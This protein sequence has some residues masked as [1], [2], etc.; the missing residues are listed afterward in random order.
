LKRAWFAEPVPLWLTILLTAAGTYL[1]TVIVRWFLPR[2][3]KIQHEIEHLYGVHDEQFRR[4]MGNLL[5]PAILGG[6][7]VTALIN[8]REIFPAMLAAIGSARRSITF[9]TFIYWSGEIGRRFADALADRARAGVK[10]HVLLD[11]LGSKRMDE[12]YLRLMQDAGVQVER[13]HRPH[14]LH[15]ASLNHRTHRKIL[16]IDGRLGF[17]GGVGIADEWLGDAQDPCHWRDTHF[18]V[19]GPVVAE[20]QAAFMDN[21]MKTHAR[22]LHGDDYFPPLT[23]VGSSPAQVFQSSPAE[24]SESVRLMY[25]MSI[26]CAR[27]R[28][29]LSSAYFVPD[30]LS[31]RAMTD[32]RGRGVEIDIIV[33][34][35]HI[36]T[37]TVR[38]A[39]RG[40]WGPLL[41]AGV[42]IHEYQPTMYH[43]K[44]MIVDDLFVSVG[45][46]NFD[47]RSFRLNDEANLNILDAAVAADQE[48]CF[49]QDLARSRQITYPEWL[50]RPL[51]EKLTERALSLIRSQL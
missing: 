33:P 14:I 17:T 30:D 27:R 41:R 8:G 15:I 37:Q 24:G 26:A 6:N 2:E 42:R 35:K 39:S 44:V 10:V 21:W 50:R 3:K 45:S 18:Q 43:T 5:P 49:Q 48:R 13:Y 4:A 51:R 20:L 9:E 11:W 7:R 34:G 29:R 40:R 1:L 38:R 46:T 12:A 36:D 25:L 16:V 28:I 31:V 23:P 19:E 47:N 22:V 32:A